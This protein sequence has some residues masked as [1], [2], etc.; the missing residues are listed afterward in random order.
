MALFIFVSYLTT[1]EAQN[2]NMLWN[3]V[4]ACNAAIVCTENEN[5]ALG[6]KKGDTLLYVPVMSILF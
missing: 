3:N 4:V 1:V 6:G 2:N 5:T